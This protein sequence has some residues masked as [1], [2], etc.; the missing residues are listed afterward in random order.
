MRQK[1]PTL[2]W[3]TLACAIKQHHDPVNAMAQLFIVSSSL[4]GVYERTMSKRKEV[5]C[6]L[7]LVW[8]GIYFELGKKKVFLTRW[9]K[10]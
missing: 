7:E 10:S 3:L 6:S 2:D 1:T 5:C 4:P 8:P 9:G